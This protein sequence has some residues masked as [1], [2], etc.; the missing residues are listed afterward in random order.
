MCDVD[1]DASYC[2]CEMP[3]GGIDTNWDT[4]QYPVKLELQTIEP[5]ERIVERRARI[6]QEQRMLWPRIG[7]K[8]LAR[9]PI[10]RKRVPGRRVV[11]S[12]KKKRHTRAAGT[13]QRRCCV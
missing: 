9:H 1:S 8:S 10:Y 11:I 7:L 12:R 6:R 3:K 13:G 4:G 5:N 2:V